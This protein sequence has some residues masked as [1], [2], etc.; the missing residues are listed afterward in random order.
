MTGCSLLGKN[1][2]ISGYTLSTFNWVVYYQSIGYYIPLGQ[3]TYTINSIIVKNPVGALEW[4]SDHSAILGQTPLTH[5]QLYYMNLPALKEILND[6]F[7][8]QD[9]P[10]IKKLNW[11]YNTDT[12]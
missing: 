3:V 10:I 2:Y 1:C 11:L 12:N 8:F 6:E 5:D 9:K 7:E 4:S